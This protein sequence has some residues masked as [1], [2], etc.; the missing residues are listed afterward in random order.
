MSIR[1]LL[2]V[3]ALS[4]ALCLVLASSV[5]VGF[6]PFRL[7]ALQEPLTAVDGRV[8]I[9]P[10][11]L[12]EA[13]A[14]PA[15]F[16]LIARLQHD[17]P[18]SE[19]FEI[20][21]DGHPVCKP[22]LR[23]GAS[24][25]IDCA[26]FET[27]TATSDHEVTVDGPRTA[28]TLQYLE[29]ATHHGATRH[30]ELLILPWSGSY[31]RPG[32]GWMAVLW[33][34]IAAAL[35]LPRPP[36]VPRWIRV[37]HVA[38]RTLIWV[39]LGAVVIS[40]FVSPFAIVLSIQAFLQAVV[41]L[42]VDRLWF[43]GA[44]LARWRSDASWQP[45]AVALVAAA[46][47]LMSYTRLA[48]RIAAD[49]YGGNY[50]GFVQLSGQVF[51]RHPTL[52]HRDDVRRSLFLHQGGGYDGQIMYFVAFDP[53]LRDFKDTPAT[54]SQFI[55]S[56]PYRFGR[57]GFSLLTKVFS[58]D[59]WQWYPAAMVGLVLTA[60]LVS[61]LALSWI[62]RSAGAAPGWGLLTLAIPGFWQS[63]QTALPEPV[64]SALL[65]GGYACLTLRRWWWAGS[66]FGLA[67]LIRESAVIFVLC[68]VAGTLWSSGRQP[69]FRLAA[70]SLA[71][72]ILWRLYVGWM[73]WP[74]LGAHGLVVRPGGVTIPLFGIGKLVAAL[75]RGDY[76][77]DSPD[78]R[79][80]AA[81][82]AVIV[83]CA[84]G[85]ASA[86]AVTVPSAI[87]VAAVLYG[88]V[89]LSLNF[90][91]VWAH[92]G[93]AQ[94]TTYEL[95]TVLALLSVWLHS[96]PRALRGAILAFWGATAWY[97]FFGAFDAYYIRHAVFA[98]LF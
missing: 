20:R 80:A 36:A 9:G 92:V 43:A 12:R 30:F 27:W 48:T 38:A 69:A 4:A 57:I 73:L 54:Y 34:G 58:A 83:V 33:L 42:L 89:A 2:P 65:L 6:R 72:S 55:D 82:F 61:A 46:A 5:Y 39:L 62:A 40:R 67:L 79:V 68:A 97:V 45:V 32:V 77:P 10:E 81:G 66:L 91:E 13:G 75:H 70:I 71:P 96:Y 86:M 64:V 17:A 23:P 29:L 60:T 25:R 76:F 78:I 26:I 8:R 85:L 22:S 14:L 49:R 19:R 63:V 84:A 56:P 47:V 31:E 21:F 74:T 24:T 16:A 93:N 35:L 7:K 15:P 98:P 11:L 51:D 53:F 94:R 41:V 1:R 37:L 18:A 50:S 3:A 87:G 88:A 28:W 44:R 59:R 52:K 95:F 90:E